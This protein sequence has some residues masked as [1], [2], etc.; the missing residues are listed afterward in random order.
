MMG[1]RQVVRRRCSTSSHLSGTFRQ[2]LAE[3]NRSLCRPVAIWSHS[4][5]ALLQSMPAWLP[6]TPTKARCCCFWWGWL[7][8][9]C[10]R[11][12]CE[13]LDTLDEAAWSAASLNVPKFIS[14]SDP[15]AQ[16]TGAH[17]GHAV[18]AYASNYLI[19]L[20]AAG[21]ILYRALIQGVL[22]WRL[23]ISRK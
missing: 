13:Y 16:G 20:K 23:T 8:R 22:I 11:S 21:D 15:A 9:H 6:L 18:F 19:D 3:V 17:K 14:K 1:Q 2:P 5:A 7:G 4:I 10:R 12:V